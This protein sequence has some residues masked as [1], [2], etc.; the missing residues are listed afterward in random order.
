MPAYSP[1]A[2]YPDSPF[3][4]NDIFN[5]DLYSGTRKPLHAGAKPIPGY[6]YTSRDWFAREVDTVLRDS[7]L[8]AVSY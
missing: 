4:S 8:L 7:W 1:S 6:C 5:P 3:D 2:E